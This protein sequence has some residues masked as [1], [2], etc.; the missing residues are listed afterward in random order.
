MFFKLPAGS[1]A[2]AR[3]QEGRVN[4][5]IRRGERFRQRPVN[6]QLRSDLKWRNHNYR[7]ILWIAGVILFIFGNLVGTPAVARTTSMASQSVDFSLFYKVSRTDIS[8]C[9]ARDGR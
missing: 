4:F 5:Y 1:L 3:H 2:V 8:E 6:E 7:D 9:R